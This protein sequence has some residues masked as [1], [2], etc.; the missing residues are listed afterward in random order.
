M[1]GQDWP[2]GAC[3]EDDRHVALCPLW[4]LIYP[5]DIRTPHKENPCPAAAAPAASPHRRELNKWRRSDTEAE[6][7]ICWHDSPP[8]LAHLPSNARMM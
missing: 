1:A 7:G 6:A 5:A 4:R 2:R 3:W 8:V